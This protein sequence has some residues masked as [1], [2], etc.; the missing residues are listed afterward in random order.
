MNLQLQYLINLQKFD[1]RI[2]QIQDQLRKAPELLKSA[3]SPLQDILARLQVLK[4]TSESLVKQRRSAERELATQEEQLQK[5]RNR[6]SELKTNKEYQAHLFEIELARKKKDSIEENVLEMM[7]RVEQNQQAI[8]E[9]EEQTTEVQKAFDIEKAR[10]ETHFANLANELADLDR[11]QNTLAELVDKPLLLRYN[12]LKTMRKGYAV[13]QLR[14]GAC[15]GCQLQLPPQ[16]VAEVK[17]GDE[18]LDCSYCHRILYLT[19]HL[20]EEITE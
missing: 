7:E 5:I 3:E 13:A 4:N 20:E 2:F 15:G 1:L 6:L 11:Q 8:K 19:S 17:R 9:L 14:H 18:L 16:L 12:R 10:L